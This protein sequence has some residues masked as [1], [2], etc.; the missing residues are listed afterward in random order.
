MLIRA[1]HYPHFYAGVDLKKLQLIFAFLFL[2]CNRW[3]YDDPS[4]SKSFLAPETYLTLVATDTIY[5]SLD[6]L[7]NTVISTN[8]DLSTEMLWDTLAQAFST[9]TSNKQELNWSGEDPDGDL[10]D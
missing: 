7:G 5:S 1:G 10:T 3:E 9:V 2:S 8:E 6:S 4:S